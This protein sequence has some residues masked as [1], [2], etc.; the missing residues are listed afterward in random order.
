MQHEIQQNC[1]QQQLSE[2]SGS[3]SSEPLSLNDLERRVST[4]M[5][6]T[7]QNM[8][9]PQP[10]VRKNLFCQRFHC[11]PSYTKH[12]ISQFNEESREYRPKSI[13]K[14]CL[15][16]NS[17]RSSAIVISDPYP[18]IPPRRPRSAAINLDSSENSFGDGGLPGPYWLHSSKIPNPLM[19]GTH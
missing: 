17:P 8:F 18:W 14:T 12:K 2:A 9:E 4:S 16:N 10:P 1:S 15:D 11:K 3:Q 13:P 6:E 7:Q 5:G 19:P